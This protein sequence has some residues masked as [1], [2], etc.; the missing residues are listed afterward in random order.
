MRRL[1]D[2]AASLV[3]ALTLLACVAGAGCGVRYYDADHRDYH[4]WD[5][6]EDRAYHDYWAERHARDPYRDYGRLD[7][8]QQNDYWNWR[9]GHPDAG[10]ND[11]DRDDRNRDR[12]DRDRH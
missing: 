8:R 9:H 3:F 11:H 4:R 6:D 12:D 2:A 1:R 5:R 10:R 7:A